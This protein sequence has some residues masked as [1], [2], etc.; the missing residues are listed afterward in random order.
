M[1]AGIDVYQ[2]GINHDLACD[3]ALAAFTSQAINLTVARAQ[4][5]LFEDGF[6]FLSPS[7]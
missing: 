4:A 2:V 5:A 3:M 6:S 7:L 1:G